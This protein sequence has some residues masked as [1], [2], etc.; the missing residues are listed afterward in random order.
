MD[1]LM[2]RCTFS[3]IFEWIW[4]ASW[5]V[6]WTP[7]VIS[8]DLGWQTGGQ[9]PGRYFSDLEMEVMQEYNSMCYNFNKDHAF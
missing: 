9:F 6:V 7:I 2:T 1:T 5:K 8:N 3:L 4:G